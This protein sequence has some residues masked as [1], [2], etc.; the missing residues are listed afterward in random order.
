MSSYYN[1][2]IVFLLS[3]VSYCDNLEC[4]SI[5]ELSATGDTLWVTRVPDIDVARSSMVIYGDTITVTG[6]NAPFNSKFR[7][8]HFTLDGVKIGQTI[9]VDHPVE[10]FTNMF[11]LTSVRFNDKTLITGS[12][13]QNGIEY[14]LV[15]VMD[16][17]DQLDTLLLLEP[18]EKISTLWDVN[19][20]NDGHFYTY[21]EIQEGG[22][23]EEYRKIN[24]FDKDFN[25]IWNY[26]S[27]AS[28]FWGSGA[29][30]E[31][32][33]DGRVLLIVYSPLSNG[34][35]SSLRAINED[36]STDWQYNPIYS[37]FL[38]KTLEK[39]S[40]VVQLPS[41]D[42][43]GMGRYT[44]ISLDEPIR[45]SPFLLKINTE[46]D[47]I[48]KR[49]FYDL[50]PVTEVSRVG[51]VKDAI[52]LENGDIYGIGWM[53]YDGQRETFIFKVDSNG[54]LDAEDCGFVQ[55][56]TAAEDVEIRN[57]IKI[58]PNPVS[59]VLTIDIDQFPEKVEIYTRDGVL[60]KSESKV[61]EIDVSG[62]SRGVYYLKVYVDGS[63]G[64]VQF[65]K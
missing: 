51:L 25:L 47:I 27:E 39:V 53:D 22:L 9:G 60:V 36:G 21:H 2:K 23:L 26:K 46:G 54:C 11:Q 42:L 5:A 40:R 50:D 45:D 59:D 19:I 43:L 7:M 18:Q 58:Y 16:K 13:I 63:I 10:K 4:S 29:L 65:I 44:N 57:D 24:K 33:K 3:L 52:E 49:V 14:G 17:D 28:P 12:G 1:I 56:I 48:W 30:G 35:L 6:N 34:S 32:M 8:A 64:L 55:L 61:K 37:P 20:D 38:D 31:V 62:L 15:Y 41:E